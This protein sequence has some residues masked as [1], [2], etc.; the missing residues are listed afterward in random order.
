MQCPKCRHEQEDG[1]A[2]CQHCGVI[3]ARIPAPGPGPDMAGHAAEPDDAA[4]PDPGLG[5]KKPA[6]LAAIGVALALIVGALWWLNFPSGL[7]RTKATHVNQEKGFA[8]TPPADWLMLTASNYQDILKPYQDHFPKELRRF[9]SAANF[10]ISFIRI[11][12]KIGDF[13]PS[14]NVIAMPLKSA[15]PPLTAGEKDKA[16]GVV[17]GEMSRLLDTY[18][19][20]SSRITEVDKLKSLEISST[21]SV[22]VI[23]TPSTPIYSESGAFGFRHVTGH[24]RE[25]ARTF[26][27][28]TL[29]TLVPGKRWAYI[30][31]CSFENADF[32]NTESICKAVVNS[33]RVK[34]RPPR[35]GSIAMGTLNGGLIG[36]G[37][38]LLYILARRLGL[39]AE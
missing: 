32:Q 14:L 24:T 12:E 27:F 17:S 4:P 19:L 31:S 7:P 26:E 6:S 15:L 10:E 5:E 33:F 34:D 35:F 23:V 22:K 16:V 8:L 37:L 38:Y 2:E 21:A 28:R 20:S 18:Q 30:I 29:Q 39:R 11:P 1:L 25:V 13:T 3:F 36:A 9:M